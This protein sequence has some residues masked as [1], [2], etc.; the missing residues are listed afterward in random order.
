M[1]KFFISMLLA[2]VF[3]LAACSGKTGTLNPS[4][5]PGTVTPSGTVNDEEDKIDN[6]G[7][8][9]EE[10]IKKESVRID[11]KDKVISHTEYDINNDGTKEVIEIILMDGQYIEDNELWAGMGKKWTGNFQITVK[12]SNKLLFS[13]SLNSLMDNIDFFYC[14]EFE[15]A[16]QDYN[17]DGRID[18]NLGQYASSVNSVYTFFTINSDGV[19]EKLPIFEGN[20]VLIMSVKGNSV[21]LEFNGDIVEIRYYDRSEGFYYIVSYKRSKGSENLVIEDTK[22]LSIE[23]DVN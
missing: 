21:P 20:D 3:L 14:P 11:M 4:D 2:I 23:V 6:N 8:A 22:K 19:I 7:D 15:L 13:S 9:I 16:L 18:F 5:N 1:K 10:N 12:D 17:G